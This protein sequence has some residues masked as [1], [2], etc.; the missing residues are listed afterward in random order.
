V[1]RNKM[2][3]ALKE[4]NEERLAFLNE[5]AEELSIQQEEELVTDYD[6]ALKEYQTKN[7]PYKVKFKGQLFDVPRSIPFSFSL[8]YM[9]HCI[10]KQGGTTVFVIPDDKQSEFIER[11]FG[12]RFLKVLEQSDD[13]ELNFVFSKLV[14]DI[15]DKWGYSVKNPKNE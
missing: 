5:K 14:P 15:M 10:K 2:D 4:K 1:E 3:D 6:A 11:M 12:K 9:R 13:V 8:F 7:K